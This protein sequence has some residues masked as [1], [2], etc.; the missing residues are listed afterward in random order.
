MP[1]NSAASLSLFGNT[2]PSMSGFSP[3]GQSLLGN[4]SNNE[5]E[6]ERR[7]KLLLQQQQRLLPNSGAGS[8]A[9]SPA[10][11]SLGFGVFT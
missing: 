8:L 11:V 5:T 7:K 9:L 4:S 10:S 3:A 6:E 2:G 1:A